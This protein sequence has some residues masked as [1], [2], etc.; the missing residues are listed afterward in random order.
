MSETS[1]VP[2]P[3]ILYCP[4]CHMRHLDDGEFAEKPHHTHA[5]QNKTCGTVWRP[6]L[7]PTVGVLTLPGFLD[8][9][10]PRPIRKNVA[11]LNQ[12]L[13]WSAHRILRSEWLADGS[14]VLRVSAKV[15]GGPFEDV[16]G[17]IE[18]YLAEVMRESSGE[19]HG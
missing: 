13:G 10:A 1:T 11:L 5:C 15:G 14:R 19:S 18:Q 12:G 3:M 9:C 4:A 8:G 6:A 7:V 17:A 2:I 16:D